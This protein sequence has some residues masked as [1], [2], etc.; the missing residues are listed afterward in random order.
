MRASS[1]RRRR[2]PAAQRGFERA[3]AWQRRLWRRLRASLQAV[4][5]RPP[6]QPAH[7]RLMRPLRLRQAGGLK[8]GFSRL[9]IFGVT[10]M[11]SGQLEML[12]ALARHVD[13]FLYVLNPCREYWFDVRYE[14]RVMH[15]Q[16]T[17]AAR[18]QTVEI[19][20]PLLAGQGRQ[21]QDFLNLLLIV[22]A[23]TWKPA[24]IQSHELHIAPRPGPQ[25]APAGPFSRTSWNCSIVAT[26]PHSAA[27]RRAAAAAGRRT[28]PTQRALP[29]LPR[30]A[31]RGGGAARPVAGPVRPP[32]GAEPR[33]VVVM[34][35]RLAPTC[36][37]FA[38]CSSVR[39]RTTHP[40]PRQRPVPA[41]RSPILNSFQTLLESAGQPPAAVGSTG[42]AGSTGH[43]PALWS[44]AGGLR[45][46]Q[47]LAGRIRC[48]L[49]G[50]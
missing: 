10:A 4:R 49:G 25:P 2:R 12:M 33:D 20:N 3:E 14:R 48:A 32:P 8:P 27:E 37:I 16:A 15:L 26:T 35:P 17:A 23:S 46:A 44:G 7:D 22:K 19:G 45:A 34:M 13:I 21:V 50:G 30:P 41:G 28:D 11:P 38:Q 47:E 43:P 6:P 5:N 31:A 42:V 39:R 40:L 9:F 24:H 29:Q 36:R 18:T 1:P